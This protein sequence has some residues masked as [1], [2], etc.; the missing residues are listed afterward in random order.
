MAVKI[1]SASLWLLRSSPE[2]VRKLERV[3]E[4]PLCVRVSYSK[5]PVLLVPKDI[6]VY[7]VSKP[8]QGDNLLFFTVKEGADFN[9]SYL[10]VVDSTSLS[11]TISIPNIFEY[12]WFDNRI[13]SILFDRFFRAARS[14]S[15]RGYKPNETRWHPHPLS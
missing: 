4:S 1:V 6:E 5:D 13:S 9:P 15:L 8:L 7:Q 12:P 14:T 3:P 11:P 2:V 10:S